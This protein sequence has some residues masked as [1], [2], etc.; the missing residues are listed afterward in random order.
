MSSRAV[1]L[2]LMIA[3][4]VAV[5]CTVVPTPTPTNAAPQALPQAPPATTASPDFDGDGKADLA[6]TY[7]DNDVWGQIRVDYGSGATANTLGTAAG[8]LARNLNGDAYTDLVVA[9]EDG[10]VSVLFGSSTGLALSSSRSFGASAIGADYRPRDLALVESPTPRIVLGAIRL[11]GSTS[12]KVLVYPIGSDGLPTSPTPSVL[13]P[14]KAGV[15][16]L[17]DRGFFG[18]VL[19]SAGNQL[20]VGV[21]Y[22]K[23]GGYTNAGALVALTFSSTGVK[24]GKVITQNTSGVGSSAARNDYFGWAAAAR[25]GYLAVSTRSDQVGSVSRA[26]S[27]QLFTLSAGKVT[28][29]TRITQ[30][31]AGVPGKVEKDDWF[32]SAVAL[33]QTC[34]GRTTLFVGGYGEGIVKGHD[35]DG[36]V[37]V[38]PLK[39][40]K[41]CPARQLWEGHGL[42][43]TPFFRALGGD[44]A[45]LRSQGT[46]YDE[47]AINGYGSFSEGPAGVLLVW[48]PQTLTT[49]LQLEG[50]FRNLAGR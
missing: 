18:E 31:T 47:L 6:T 3:A 2:S 11:S 25:G 15:P 46:T 29:R 4:L 12:G 45:L 20:F 9:A 35:D 16:K 43:G 27:V 49:R 14:G 32:G 26:G 48:S 37:W 34:D 36:S 42:P 30:A 1:H 8:L 50:H 21:P 10:S 13:Q 40:T 41:A 24:S 17:S 44:L 23:V 33:G 28:P 39:A 22:A 38:L 5:G 19:A 7:D